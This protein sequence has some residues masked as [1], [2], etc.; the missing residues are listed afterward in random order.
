MPPAPTLTQAGERVDCAVD[1]VKSWAYLVDDQ[2]IVAALH[3][4][5]QRP[6]A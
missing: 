1:S 5:N 6:A 3:P 4:L 2:E